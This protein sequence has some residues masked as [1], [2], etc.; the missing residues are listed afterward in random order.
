MGIETFGGRGFPLFVGYAERSKELEVISWNKDL[1]KFDFLVVKGY[2]PGGKPRIE[3]AHKSVCLTCHQGGGPIFPR[4]PWHEST[5]PEEA[6]L[7]L[8]SLLFPLSLRGSYLTLSFA[9][10]IKS[11]RIKRFAEACGTDLQCRA[12]VLCGNHWASELALGSPSPSAVTAQNALRRD[13]GSCQTSL[14]FE[15]F[16]ISI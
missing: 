16:F 8:I 6:A 12:K 9:M 1:Q 5:V 13:H 14:A 3:N 15:W 10:R 7:T 11:Y 2:G 4:A